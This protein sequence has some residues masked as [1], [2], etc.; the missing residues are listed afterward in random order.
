MARP[1]TVVIQGDASRLVAALRA[2]DASMRP[3]AD[4]ARR[5]RR[6]QGM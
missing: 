4:E 2:V 5:F 1:V 6:E 3:S